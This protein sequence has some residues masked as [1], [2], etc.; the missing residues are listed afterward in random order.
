VLGH[1]LKIWADRYAFVAESKGTAVP[2]RPTVICITSQYHPEEIWSDTAT[3]DAIK[4]RFKIERIGLPGD[5]PKRMKAAFNQPKVDVTADELTTQE[6]D[7]V[8]FVPAT[9]P[10]GSSDSET[11]EEE[12]QAERHRE[13]ER[14]QTPVNLPSSKKKKIRM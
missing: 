9:Q 12:L 5:A 14:R 2:L 11:D 6:D 7:D 8:V 4:R 1:H 10:D 13:W 3:L